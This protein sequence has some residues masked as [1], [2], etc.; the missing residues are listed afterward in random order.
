MSNIT[1]Q[2]ELKFPLNEVDCVL[3][4]TVSVTTRGADAG[5]VVSPE[6]A[7]GTL[8]FLAF[9]KSSDKEVALFDADK[10]SPEY[11]DELLTLLR[12]DQNFTP[13]GGQI[14]SQARRN[15]G[16]ILD[17]LGFNLDRVLCVT[18]STVAVK[19]FLEKGVSR[20]VLFA[21]N[22]DDLNSAIA[23]SLAKLMDGPEKDKVSLLGRDI[24][25]LKFT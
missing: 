18:S 25:K 14:F 24:S 15:S 23:N 6:L 5:E 19:S 9:L 12:A 21:Y 10:S 16:R 22:P 11:N 20:V 4:Q 2:D 3:V 8:E 17:D 13:H 7:I 1:F